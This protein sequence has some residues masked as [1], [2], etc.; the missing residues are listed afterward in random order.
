MLV[1]FETAAGFALFKVLKDKKL[2]KISN[3]AEEFSTLDKATKI[4]KLKA[5]EKF[6][7]SKSAL[8]AISVL[9]NK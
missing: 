6:N 8:K 9:V 4:V 3:L 7:D 5:F 1:L 2:K